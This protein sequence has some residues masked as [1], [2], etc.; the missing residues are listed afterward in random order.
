MG[1][2]SQVLC[3]K[4][5][6]IINIELEYYTDEPLH[7]CSVRPVYDRGMCM[8]EVNKSLVK[9]DKLYVFVSFCDSSHSFTFYGSSFYGFRLAYN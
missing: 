8:K 2:V 6:W 9:R 7:I 3:I 5:M 1:N 4:P